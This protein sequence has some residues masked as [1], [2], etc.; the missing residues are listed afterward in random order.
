MNSIAS[1]NFFGCCFLLIIALT[2]CSDSDNNNDDSVNNEVPV[3]EL[4]SPSVGDALLPG[5]FFDDRG[6]EKA[7]YFISGTAES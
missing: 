5:P 1:F 3:P 7:E 6:Y 2:G 4:S